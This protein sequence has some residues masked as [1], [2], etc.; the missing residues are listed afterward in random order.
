ML[1][2]AIKYVN[3]KSHKTFLAKRLDKM[4]SM[5]YIIISRCINGERKECR[6]W[7]KN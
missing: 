2:T 6:L 1:D 5:C 7:E 4:A 3:K